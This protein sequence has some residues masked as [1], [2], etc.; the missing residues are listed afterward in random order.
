MEGRR[1]VPERGTMAAVG[2][3]NGETDTEMH[4]Q[5]KTQPANPPTIK[6]T[7]LE[8]GGG[9]ETSGESEAGETAQQP[10]L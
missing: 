5:S 1:G 9:G 3:A 2:V 7:E 8:L 4:L 6:T 10:G